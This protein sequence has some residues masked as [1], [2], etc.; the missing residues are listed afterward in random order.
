MGT[1]MSHN[2]TGINNLLQGKLAPI[3]APN[4]VEIAVLAA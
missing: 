1:L 2:P 3:N 4:D